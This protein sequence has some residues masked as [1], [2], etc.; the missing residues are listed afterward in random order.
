MALL[1]YR[2]STDRRE[3]DGSSARRRFAVSLLAAAMG[4][5]TLGGCGGGG[6]PTTADGSITAPPPAPATATAEDTI[7]PTVSATAE[8]TPVPTASWTTVA[9]TLTCEHPDG[10][11]LTYPADWQTYPDEAD[12]DLGHLACGIFGTAPMV[13]EPA[14]SMPWLPIRVW[15]WD[16]LPF[17]DATSPQFRSGEYPSRDLEVESTSVAG[18]PAVR[19][20]SVSEAPEGAPPRDYELPNGTESV[21]WVVDLST[22]TADRVLLGRAIPPAAAFTGVTEAD[23]SAEGATSVDSTAEVLDAMMAS[24]TLRR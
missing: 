17:E 19:V 8:G 22:D 24:L 20:V 16:G 21:L 15:V 7:T 6:Q 18:R 9:E 23:K 3:P 12:P 4:V 5:L 13:L 2:V 11:S 14:T 10:Y 1:A